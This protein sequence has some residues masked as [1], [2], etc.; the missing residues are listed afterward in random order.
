MIKKLI[1]SSLHRMGI[2]LTQCNNSEKQFANDMGW[3]LASLNYKDFQI[4]RAIASS[5]HITIEEAQLLSTLA[6][7][8]LETDP[9]IEIGT[10]FGFSTIVL[11][12][13]KHPSQQL[14]TVDRFS[15]NPFGISPLAHK[16]GTYAALRDANKNHNTQII[17]QDKDEFYK[18]YDGPPPGLF[19]CDANHEYEPTLRDLDWA[20]KVGAKIICGHDYNQEK[21][22]GVVK[23]VK[24]LG[25]QGC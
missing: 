24:E 21:F 6:R 4:A 23:A 22:P 9:I 8:T 3:E 5:G 19:F 25:G 12:V 13:S 17:H 16:L 11:A 2:E 18:N 10:L 20:R 14:I 1:K 15:W 7:E